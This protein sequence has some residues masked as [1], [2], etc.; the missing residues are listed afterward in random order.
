M[1]RIRLRHFAAS[2]ALAL[3]LAIVTPPAAAQL[4]VFD[5][6]NFSQN[7]LTAARQLTIDG[8]ADTVRVDFGSKDGSTQFELLDLVAFS[9]VNRYG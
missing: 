6:K 2:T 4:I 9:I 3:S 1:I 8:G 5:P 7:V